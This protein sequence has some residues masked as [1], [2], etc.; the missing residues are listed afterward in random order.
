VDGYST[1][2]V[3]IAPLPGNADALVSSIQNTP[4]SCGTPTVPAEQ[5]AIQY[6][7]DWAISHP[8]HVVVVVLATDG[9]PD[10]CD[11]GT[12][13]DVANVAASGASGS[14]SI[15]TYVIGVGS[16][17][18]NLN[19]IASAGGTDHAYIVDTTQDTKQQFLDQMR[20]VRGAAAL[21]CEY[22]I[23][24]PVNG[25]EIDFSKVNVAFTPS[26]G[27][28][29]LIKQTPDLSTCDQSAGGWYYDNPSAPTRI[30]LCNATCDQVAPDTGGKVDLLLGCKTEM[31]QIR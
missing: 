12:V 5:G 23:P 14:P 3:G 21:P 22:L 13:A 9:L 19:E 17:L 1:P 31:A 10:Q 11:P 18:T 29:T 24:T 15:D 26:G 20:T 8:G 4:N 6:A 28:R 25:G 30:N 2:N 27:D 16:E 7:H